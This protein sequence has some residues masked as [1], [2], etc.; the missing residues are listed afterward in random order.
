[1]FF[2]H[3]ALNRLYQVGRCICIFLF[4]CI[5]FQSPSTENKLTGQQAYRHIHVR[6]VLQKSPVSSC[7]KTNIALFPLWRVY[8]YPNGWY[9]SLPS[10]K[11]HAHVFRCIPVLHPNKIREGIKQSLLQEYQNVQWY[12]AFCIQLFVYITAKCLPKCT[13]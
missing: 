9:C 1:M 3:H 4:R 7:H 2:P 13:S 6:A 10:K 8:Q 12:Y 11:V 5:L